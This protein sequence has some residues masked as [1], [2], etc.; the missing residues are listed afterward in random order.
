[1]PNDYTLEDYKEA[2]LYAH[3]NGL[4]GITTFRDGTRDGV[5]ISSTTSKKEEIKEEV[6]AVEFSRPRVLDAKS[7][8]ILEA[9][10]NHTYCI[11]SHADRD[12]KKQP[13]EM[14]MTA[15]GE[16]AEWYAIIG[17]LASRLMRKTGDAEGVVKELKSIGGDNGYFTQQYGYM[18]SRPQHLGFIL[19]EYL[20]QL[21]Q[22]NTDPNPQF[23]N[24]KEIKTTSIC[25][26]CGGAI[27]KRGGC[28]QC[29]NGCVE[30][31]KCG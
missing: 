1:M 10:G 18:N 13:W 21:N 22:S 12:G 14:F 9:S 29:E 28:K 3:E 31:Y 15:S 2:L 6:P 25:D 7:Y 26:I 5:F 19:E 30:S 23:N 24:T 20:D 8:Q 4:K 27:V 17:R 11:L 16:H